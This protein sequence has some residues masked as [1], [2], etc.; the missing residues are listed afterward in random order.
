MI[1]SRQS[2]SKESRVQFF[3][4][5]HERWWGGQSETISKWV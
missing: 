3:W 5:S 1:K 2:Y 4:P